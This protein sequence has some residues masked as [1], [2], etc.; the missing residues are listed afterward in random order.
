MKNSWNDR[1]NLKM[2]IVEAR[3]QYF[4]DCLLNKT[5]SV[6]ESEKIVEKIVHCNKILFELKMCRKNVNLGQNK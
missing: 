4:L 1:T 2:K 6:F 5:P 3:K